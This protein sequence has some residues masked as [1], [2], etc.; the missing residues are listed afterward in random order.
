MADE[1]RVRTSL[2]V[3]MVLSLTLASGLVRAGTPSFEAMHSYDTGPYAIR[4]SPQSLAV[5]DWNGDGRADLAAVGG[6][7]LSV[8]LGGPGRT[9]VP[10]PGIAVGAGADAL[11]TGR[12]DGDAVLDLVITRGSAVAFLRGRGD[13]AFDAPVEYPTGGLD[14]NSVALGDVNGDGRNDLA[15]ANNYDRVSVFLGNG[16]GTFGAPAHFAAGPQPQ[17][18]VLAD[19]DGDGDQDLAVA[20]LWWFRQDFRGVSVLLGNGDGTFAPRVEDTSLMASWL[21]VTDVDRDGTLDLLAASGGDVALLQGLGGGRF[22]A[23]RGLD[24]PTGFGASCV[25]AGDLDGDGQLDLVTTGSSD[26]GILSIRYGSGPGTYRAG[27]TYSTGRYPGAITLAHLDDDDALD[28]ALLDNL[29]S[30]SV[31]WGRGGGT[32]HAG[33]AMPSIHAKSGIFHDVNGDGLLDFAALAAGSEDDGAPRREVSVLLASAN[34]EFSAP[35]SSA[36]PGMPGSFAI[37]DLNGDGRPDVAASR[38]APTSD[39][40]PDPQTVMVALGRGDGTFLPAAE[41]GVGRYPRSVAVG[42]LNR[43]GRPD[44]VVAHPALSTEV[45]QSAGCSVL[46]GMGDGTFAAARFFAVGQDPGVMALADLD[47]DRHVDLVLADS[48]QILVLRGRGDGTFGSAE[49]HATAGAA[50]MI[51]RDLNGDGDVD[52][53]ATDGTATLSVFLGDG[54]GSF[55]PRV[56]YRTMMVPSRIAVADVDGDARLDLAVA[57]RSGVQMLMGSRGGAFDP[58]P[59][60]FGHDEVRALALADVDGDGGSDIVQQTANRLLVLC[61][62][63]F[64]PLVIDAK[65]V[66]PAADFAISGVSP[67]P[68]RDEL[69]IRFRL[70]RESLVDVAL[71]DLS[72]RRVRA[73]A[74]GARLTAGPHEMRLPRRGE[75]GVALPAGIYFVRIRAGERT[76]VARAILL[77]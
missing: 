15:V 17:H 12:I 50:A 1:R 72:G 53:A 62:S 51:V 20:N 3:S 8:L 32:F 28:L 70:P 7:T 54:R 47:R 73:I 76:A 44:L 26:E 59:F 11:A 34:G 9:F 63:G 18:V 68:G 45:Q 64:T 58:A 71:H 52:V 55:A 67:N 37:A 61:N 36:L 19:L 30:V 39:T 13:G 42:D 23:A 25:A 75:D 4:S 56:D 41:F 2:I 66:A 14:A 57:C 6:T 10:L 40:P 24:V 22:A 43:D 38:S 35:R 48:R 46:L 27:P 77:D 29:N 33:R 65:P 69:S 21:S 74:H 5:G 16:D 31:L 60:A 49:A